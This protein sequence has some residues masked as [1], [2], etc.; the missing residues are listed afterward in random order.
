MPGSEALPRYA[1]VVAEI[2]NRIERGLYPPGS[3]LPSEH[4][5]TGEFGVSRPTI[6][7]SSHSSGSGSPPVSAGPVVT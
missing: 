5:L 4:Q 3:L 7:K 6:V 2:K 1:Q